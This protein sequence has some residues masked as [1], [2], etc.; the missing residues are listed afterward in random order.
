MEK[1]GHSMILSA[2]AHDS[3]SAIEA[4]RD[5]SA[6]AIDRYITYYGYKIPP[7]TVLQSQSGL[8][9]SDARPEGVCD[10]SDTSPSGSVTDD[11]DDGISEYGMERG[12]ARR[13]RQHGCT[14]ARV[15]ADCRRQRTEKVLQQPDLHRPVPPRWYGSQPPSMPVPAPT[16]STQVQLARLLVVAGVPPPP[17]PPVSHPSTRQN[18]YAALLTIHW[19][20]NVTKSMAVKI[21]PTKQSLV[22]LAIKET[23]MQ[24][25]TFAD[26]EADFPLRSHEKPNGQA[27][28]RR[29]ALGG[30]KFEVSAFGDDLS[31]C[32]LLQPYCHS[33]I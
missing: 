28:V 25:L 24:P 8:G 23:R 7:S 10:T 26:V 3:Q 1:G 13:D 2:A 17:S 22:R 32:A 15:V 9:G 12:I 4:L 14:A 33:R 5:N 30:Q 21:V 19:I 20:G 18:V 27:I 11:S 16:Q 31:E 29:V 6:R